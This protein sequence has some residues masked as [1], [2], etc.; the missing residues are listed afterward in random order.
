M[1]ELYPNWK[2]LWFTEPTI[3]REGKFD[4]IYVSSAWDTFENT[5]PK[6]LEEI[7]IKDVERVQK[8]NILP[9][10]H[11]LHRKIIPTTFV[12]V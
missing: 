9:R 8:N 2:P 5:E 6:E 1:K 11:K 12:Y 3:K 7:F 4:A 10:Q